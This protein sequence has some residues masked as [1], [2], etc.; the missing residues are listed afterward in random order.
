MTNMTS[1]ISGVSIIEQTAENTTAPFEAPPTSV[2]PSPAPKKSTG[3]TKEMREAKIAA[4][5]IPPEK[6]RQN[7]ETEITEEN[8]SAMAQDHNEAI[9]VLENLVAKMVAME[10]NGQYQSM[11]TM[12]FQHGGVY[13]GPNY[14]DELRAACEFLNAR[15]LQGSS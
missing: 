10:N 15:K 12:F 4:G 14:V 5:W 2:P 3:F 9:R 11:W 7:V 1:S 8:V 13:T 6:R